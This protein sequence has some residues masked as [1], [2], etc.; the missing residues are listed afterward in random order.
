MSSPARLLC[1]VLTLAA[2]SAAA[3]ISAPS[4]L[5]PAA[6]PAPPTV[7]PR[8]IVL[9]PTWIE[10]TGDGVDRVIVN[11]RRM[12]LRGLEI[13]RLGPAQPE[14]DGGA[15]APSW[16]PAGAAPYRFW[17]G[18]ELYAADSFDGE[19]RLVA[20]LPAEPHGAFDWLGGVGLTLPGGS[21]SAPGVSGAAVRLDLPPFVHA[22]AADARRAV[23][24]TAL[25]HARLTLDGGASYRD[26]SA[27]LGGAVQLEVRGDEIAALLP[28][29]RERFV[30]A[31]G[32]ITGAG[33]G[34][35]FAARGRRPADEPDRFPDLP[36]SRALDAAVRAGVPLP[37]GSVV[38][39]EPGFVARVDPATL[40]TT[41][42]VTL[43]SGLRGAECSPI[44]TAD[45]LLLA[46]A[47]HE[48]AAVVDLGGAPRTERTFD[49]AGAPDLDRFVG[50]DGEALGYLGPCDGPAPPRD[51]LEGYPGGEPYNAS[52]KRTPVFCARAGHDA[53][54]EHRLEAADAADVIAWIPRAGGGAVA[55]VARWGPFLD[56]RERVTVRGSLRVVRV[57]RSEPPF[58]ISPYGWEP[59]AVLDRA[60]RIG[61]DD[62]VEG[63]L[64]ASGNGVGLLA[65]SIAARGHGAALPG[66]PRAATIT[67]AGR[68][69]LAQA[70]DG[71]LWETTDGGHRWIAVEPPPG[72]RHGTGAGAPVSACSPAGCRLGPYARLGWSPP[73]GAAATLDEAAPLEPS[74]PRRAAPQALVRLSC[75][76][77]G[78][79]EGR[80]IADSAGFG[81]TP[82]AQPRGGALVKLGQLGMATMPYNGPSMP[83]LGDVELGWVAPLDT[84]AVLRRATV[85]LARLGLAPGGPR[86]HEVRLGWLLT[87][88]GGLETFPVGPREP[89]LA[90]LLELTGISRPL[91]GCADD[92]SVGVDLGGRVILVHAAQETLVVSAADLPSHPPRRGARAGLGPPVAV[93]ELHVRPV[94]GA[95]AGFT[96]GVGARAGV[97][98]VVVLDR[99]GA[100][101]LAAI[102][103]ERG[104]LG[105]E[106]RL[107]SLP[108]AVL[109]SDPACAPR[110]GE[111]T[112]V[113]PFED[114]IGLDSRREAL[115]GISSTSNPGVAV[116]RWSRERACLDA[117]ELSV[118]DERFAESQGPYEPH[119]AL[120]KVIA[121]FD[122]A[123]RGAT[124][125]LVAGGS[126]VRQRL[127]CTS[128][129]PGEAR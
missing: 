21:L 19:L 38:I 2:C 74:R 105:A 17:K 71:K 31:T 7:P 81:Y 118:R 77:D 60:L 51:D 46:C 63:W 107:R 55:L 117:A 82:V 92:A 76:F 45:A 33:L 87:P 73:G 36:L 6:P 85:P 125:L 42:L 88:D 78:A 113:L 123:R 16:S 97:P 39:A 108:E 68:F 32:A 40:R 83:V 111:A 100:A 35:A 98:V 112:V 70:D 103:P 66:P 91:G 119:G 11:G 13:A 44:R 121:R 101:S 89:C 104:T 64:T 5:V 41:S 69:A 49:L 116:L 65:V 54:V 43:D 95:L 109:G 22:V 93:R 57:A 80:R 4:P 84:T 37:D 25:G 99:G 30:S 124:L 3:P 12:E 122:G 128:L 127:R 10:R 52:R 27:E 96:F 53:W 62:A 114:V 29:G 14:V 1:A 58:A 15:R 129:A 50:V 59:A 47:D 9:A 24:I 72:S 110:A 106:E 34:H 75:A 48:H 23:V 67:S 126:E 20:S 18:R 90:G 79:P 8:Y 26:A 94:G 115:R 56:D 61:P 102:D 120:R 28:D 86:M